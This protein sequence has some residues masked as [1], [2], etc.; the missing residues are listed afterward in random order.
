MERFNHLR[1][2]LTRRAFLGR[3]SAGMG[4][5]ALASLLKPG[6][7]RGAS[8][9]TQLDPWLGVVHPL[10]FAPKAKRVIYLYMAG[11]PSHLETFDYRPKLAQMHGKPMPESFT[12][13]QPIAQLQGQKLHCFGP[14]H[15]FKKFGKNGQEIAEI[16]PQIGAVADDICIIRSM[17]TEAINHDPAHTFMNTG[18][19]I[20]GRP[21][22][23]SW[24]LYGLGSKSDNL[25]GFVVL[26][27][28]GK[29]GQQQPIS[30]RQ[31]HSGFLPSRF[32]GVEFR[33]KGHPVL[34]VNNPRGV[35]PERQR[36]IVD[37]VQQLNRLQ[38]SVV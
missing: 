5:V 30:A 31:W 20:S 11:G 16:F 23:G 13:G 27:S 10:H 24:L 25:P 7:M 22:M 12:R 34:Y 4:M 1:T 38:N 2:L 33:S 18:T 15:K 19:T 36:D 37:A 29:A 32:Q 8:G 35:N 28:T 14:Q 17:K 21:A 6:L 9:S 26:I 3:S